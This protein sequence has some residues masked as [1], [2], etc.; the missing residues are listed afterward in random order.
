[1]I[2]LL[3]GT[4]GLLLVLLITAIVYAAS[5]RSELDEARAD[6]KA[7]LKANEL[8]GNRV[9]NMRADIIALEKNIDTL[10]SGHDRLVDERDQLKRQIGRMEAEA[11]AAK[12]ALPVKAGA[13]SI[14][15]TPA[16][17]DKGKFLPKPKAPKASKPAKKPKPVSCG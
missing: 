5:Y 6:F 7:E 4:A 9:T 10:R 3:A 15:F 11:R 12:L 1:M 14:A 17:D 16:R 2:E 13:G 8:L